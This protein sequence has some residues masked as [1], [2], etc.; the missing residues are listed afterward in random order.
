MRRSKWAR[1]HYQND[2]S[3]LGGDMSILGI[4]DEQW[5]VRRYQLQNTGHQKGS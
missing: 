4:K 3:L 2:R 1:T 5:G